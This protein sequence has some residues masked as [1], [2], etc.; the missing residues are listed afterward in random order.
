M[1]GCPTTLSLLSALA[2]GLPGIRAERAAR[3]SIIVPCACTARAS[4]DTKINEMVD[5]ELCLPLPLF[6]LLMRSI[7]CLHANTT[8][9]V[10][11][12]LHWLAGICTLAAVF[13][14]SWL[15]YSTLRYMKWMMSTCY[16]EAYLGKRYNSVT[17]YQKQYQHLTC[18]NKSKDLPRNTCKY[19][20]LKH[21]RNML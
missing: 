10:I 18:K 5:N 4:R 6:V 16:R 11:A 20:I 9:G 13:I 14:T 21:H 2:A 3:D 7:Y 12:C 1:G 8:N 19:Q 15:M 17:L